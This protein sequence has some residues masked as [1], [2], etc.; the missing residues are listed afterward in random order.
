VVSARSL[1]GPDQRQQAAS[2]TSLAPSQIPTWG[3]ALAARLPPITARREEKP[4][5]WPSWPPPGD[6]SC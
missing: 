1:A 3:P 6:G 4:N 5:G 2:N